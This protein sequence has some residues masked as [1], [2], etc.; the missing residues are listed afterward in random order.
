[1]IGEEGWLATAEPIVPRKAGNA[2]EGSGDPLEGRGEQRNE[3]DGGNM[4]TPRSLINMSTK[5]IPSGGN[6][7]ARVSEGGGCR[8][9][10]AFLYGHVVG[11]DGYRQGNAYGLSTASSTRRIGFST[12]GTNRYRFRCRFRMAR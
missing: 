3:L 5:H 10:M 6:L 12:V 9:F 1:M 11:N 8:Q 2:G 4:K 7:L